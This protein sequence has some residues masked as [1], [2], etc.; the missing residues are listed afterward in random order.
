MNKACSLHGKDKKGVC[1]LEWKLE[2]NRK[3]MGNKHRW[4]DNT[5]KN[6]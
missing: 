1:I 3:L 4:E 5:I 2:E 6:F